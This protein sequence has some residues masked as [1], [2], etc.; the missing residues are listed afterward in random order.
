MEFPGVDRH[1]D[2]AARSS[3]RRRRADR[4]GVQRPGAHRRQRARAARSS[5]TSITTPATPAYGAINW[6]DESA[7]ACGEMVFDLIAAL[8]VPLTLEIAT[9]IYLAILTDTGSFH[10]SNITPRTFD[11]CRQ[12]RRGRRESGDDGAA[13][14]RQ[15]Q[16]RQAEADRRAARRD[17]ARSTAA[18]SRSL[19]L[20]DDDAGGVR[21]HLQRHRGADQPAADRER[22]PGGRLL[23]ASAERRGPRQH[24][25]EVRRRHPRASPA[26]SAAAATR[27]PPASPSPDHS[28]ASAPESSRS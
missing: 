28:K 7:A 22:D 11:I 24:A 13:R 20:D 26:N 9:H 14:L 15:Q 4:H 5:S 21:R 6:F 3:G 17:A 23:Q 12:T 25:V 2:R 19:Y 10:Y 27:T 1:R 18:G 16:L 8:G